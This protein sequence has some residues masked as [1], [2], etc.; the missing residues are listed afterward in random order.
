LL[1]FLSIRAL[2]DL[3]AQPIKLIKRSGKVGFQLASFTL[4]S[5][6]EQVVINKNV[7]HK[8]DQADQDSQTPKLT[9]VYSETALSA[10]IIS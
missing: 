5:F 3:L 1:S 8:S 7:N 6:P 4:D 10:L 9:S 2:S